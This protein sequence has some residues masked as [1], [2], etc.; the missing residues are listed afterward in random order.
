VTDAPEFLTDST[1]KVGKGVGGVGEWQGS[2]RVIT[3]RSEPA[4]LRRM[5][6]TE[7][8]RTVSPTRDSGVYLERKE[9]RVTKEMNPAT[10]EQAP[11]VSGPNSQTTKKYWTMIRRRVLREE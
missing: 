8:P 7:E 10:T 6:P 3:R 1:K 2:E 11:T 5:N 4:A 9:G